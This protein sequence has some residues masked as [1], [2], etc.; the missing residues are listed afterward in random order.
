M[1]SINSPQREIYSATPETKANND[2]KP[3]NSKLCISKITTN[4]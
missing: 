1:L 3:F 2:T 4:N